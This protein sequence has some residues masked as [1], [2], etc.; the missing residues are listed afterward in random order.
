MTKATVELTGALKKTGLKGIFD[1]APDGKMTVSDL[2]STMDIEPRFY[3]F[4][5]AVAG[6]EKVPHE[7][8]IRDGDVIKLFIPSGGG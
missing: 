5:F 4:I 2:L 1:I 8:V 3:R 6:E 7:Y